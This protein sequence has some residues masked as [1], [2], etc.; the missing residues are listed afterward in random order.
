M[1]RF[2]EVDWD[3]ANQQSES[4][5]SDAHWHPCRFPSQVPAAAL[6]RLTSVGDRVLDPF[7]G[8]G[9]TLVEAQRLGRASVG[10]DINPI[11][12]LMAEAKTMPGPAREIEQMLLHSLKE[13][14][15]KWNQIGTGKVPVTVQGSKWYT[16]RTLNDLGRLWSFLTTH[17]SPILPILRASFSSILL[18]ACRETRHWGY[19]CDNTTPK[20]DRERNVIQL[21]DDA[22]RKYVAAYRERDVSAGSV[23]PCEIIRGDAEE[24][25]SH[26]ENG[27][28]ACFVTSP[29]YFGVSDYIKSQR[30][31]M[32]WFEH[33]LEAFRLREIGARSKRHRRTA[34]HDYHA[35]MA[36]V[37]EQLHRVLARNGWGLIVYGTSPARSADWRTMADVVERAGFRI[38]HFASRQIPVTRRQYPSIQDEQVCLVRKVWRH[39]DNSV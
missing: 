9:T 22:V 2:V 11:S 39:G 4:L 10:I 32:E 30:L 25:L 14:L 12:C 20:S 3:F 35:E 13:L 23:Q 27:S 19:V 8:S 38:E 33:D 21:F 36:R 37:F 26:M 28:F 5:F 6:E 1:R 18:Q 7:L 24:I 29:P 34:F 31:S 15:A 16:S 17:N